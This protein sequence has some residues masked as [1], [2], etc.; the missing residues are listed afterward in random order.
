MLQRHA[1]RTPKVLT[2]W[3]WPPSLG[4]EWAAPPQRHGSSLDQLGHGVRSGEGRRFSENHSISY[5]AKVLGPSCMFKPTFSIG[6]S[7]SSFPKVPQTEPYS[8]HCQNT[9]KTR[10]YGHFQAIC[11]LE[12][13]IRMFKPTFSHS[14]IGKTASFPKVPETEPHPKP[15]PKRIENASLAT[16][17]SHL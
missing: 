3:P 13:M 8:N 9:S 2:P 4:R 16:F 12:Y 17:F 15:S 5:Q 1:L 11:K 14:R 10:R 6:N 7:S